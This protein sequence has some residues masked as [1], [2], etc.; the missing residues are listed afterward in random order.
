MKNSLSTM[1]TLNRGGFSAGK[2]LGRR[3]K[4][5][6]KT[7]VPPK[8]QEVT[9]VFSFPATFLSPFLFQSLFFTKKIFR[10]VEQKVS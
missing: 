1:L 4:A 9:E 2:D 7:F 10:I 3:D 5:E 6:K 8:K